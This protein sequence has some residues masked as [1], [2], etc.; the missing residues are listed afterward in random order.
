MGVDISGRNPIIRS[1][2]PKW[3]E[4]WS[5]LSE[6][7]KDEFIRLNNEFQENNPGDYFRGIGS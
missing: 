5:E 6:S 4:N 3:P 2:K 1:E 7:A